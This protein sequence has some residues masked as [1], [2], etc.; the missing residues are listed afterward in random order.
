VSCLPARID[1]DDSI[2]AM[3]ESVLAVAPPRFALAGHS[4][5]GIVALQICRRDPARVAKLALLNAS[6][7]PPTEAQLD[8]WAELRDRT[9]AGEFTAVAGE[10]AVVNAGA[11]GDSALIGRCI[12]MAVRVGPDGFLRQL[13]AQASRPDSRPSLAAMSI[14]TIVIS[15]AD[16]TV[17]PPHLQREV[18][19]SIPE[20]WH[21][22]IPGAGHM[23][24]LDHPA[25]VAAHLT[26]WLQC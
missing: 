22:M 6:G 25:E 14:P 11:N 1:L 3:A 10:Q 12:D 2:E 18:A 16:D 21:V 5:G 13:R 26:E 20:A 8:A 17:C 23:A 24:P 9:A 19:E 15:G 7:R 4:L